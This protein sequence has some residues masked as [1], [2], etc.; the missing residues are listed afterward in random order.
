[1]AILYRYEN[2]EFIVVKSFTVH[3]KFEEFF[4]HNHRGYEILYVKKGDVVQLVEGNAYHVTDGG[5]V[6]VRSDEFHQ[7]LPRDQVYERIVINISKQFFINAGI[8]RAVKLFENRERGKGNLITADTVKFFSLDK[9]FERICGYIGENAP[10]G[11]ICGAMTELLYD[12]S[13]A[14][15]EENSENPPNKMILSVCN[16]ISSNYMF[17]E[18]INDLAEKFFVSK[19][20]LCRKFKKETGFTLNRYITNK[21]LLAVKKSVQKGETLSKAALDAGFSSYTGFYKAYVKETGMPPK[22]MLD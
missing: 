13:K 11:V 16:Y 18:N 6:I 5:I 22:K 21:R 8:E 19:A 14:K 17:I 10:G 9:D 7:L 12:L 3:P 2:P 1:M 15:P 20:H 4:L